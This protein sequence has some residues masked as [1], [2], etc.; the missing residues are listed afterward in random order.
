MFFFKLLE[1]MMACKE[2][3]ELKFTRQKTKTCRNNSRIVFCNRKR[4]L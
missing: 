3:E 2:I 1:G 4:V